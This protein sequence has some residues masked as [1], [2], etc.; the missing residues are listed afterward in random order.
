MP[1]ASNGVDYSLPSSYG[2]NNNVQIGINN[3][4]NVYHVPFDGSR[5]TDA[6]AVHHSYAPS[7]E[8]NT[9]NMPFNNGKDTPESETLS[10]A[11]FKDM[12]DFLNNL[13]DSNSF[14]HARPPGS[15]VD[16]FDPPMHARKRPKANSKIQ[17][18]TFNTPLPRDA[19]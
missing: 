10:P 9:V 15:N 8:H 12:I 17:V 7:T 18:H 11:D 6:T 1:I 5:E 16:H 4:N 2:T 3:V 14:T 19:R 13:D